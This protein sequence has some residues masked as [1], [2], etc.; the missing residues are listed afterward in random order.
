MGFAQDAVFSF[1]IMDFWLIL[2]IG[3]IKKDAHHGRASEKES[4]IK[5]T[6]GR[7]P[8]LLQRP[9]HSNLTVHRLPVVQAIALLCSSI[10]RAAEGRDTKR[11]PKPVLGQGLREQ[12]YK[13]AQGRYRRQRL[14][15]RHFKK[16]DE[17]NTQQSSFRALEKVARQ[18]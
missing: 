10:G 9:Y 4:G 3:G 7:L 16:S 12:A 8:R 13:K 2:D 5:K 6:E 17:Q 11:Q 1:I 18:Q 14:R 15:L